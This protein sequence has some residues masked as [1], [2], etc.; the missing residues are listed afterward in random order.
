MTTVLF[1]GSF[2]PVTNGHLDLLERLSAMYKR[3]VVAVGFNHAKPGWLPV[4]TRVD[5]LEQ[6]VAANPK[7]E[8]VR[9][10]RFDGMT[11]DYA[12]QV[13][14]TTIVKGVRG[15]S[16]WEWEYT[17]ATINRQISGLETLIMPSSPQWSAVSSSIV[18]ELVRF[19]API[20]RYV[21]PLV[22]ATIR[23]YIDAPQG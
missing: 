7:L 17:Q 20:S 11:T 21:P 5:V 12:L 15:P 13:G 2:D 22:E 19:D 23:A 16:D 3:V 8:N 14:A 18:R 1:P 6:I 4:D 10:G 9:V